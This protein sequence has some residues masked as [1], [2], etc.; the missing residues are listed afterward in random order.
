VGGLTFVGLGLHDVRDLSLKGFDAARSADAVFLEAYTSLLAGA[1][2]ETLEAHLGR[3]VEPLT[4]A[5]VEDGSAVLQAAQRGEAVLL[6]V[7]DSMMATTHVDL[8]VRA[9]KLGIA[10]RV[11][12]GASVLIAAAGLLGL[13]SYKFGRATTL[14][15]PHGDYLAESPYDVIAEN[16]ARGL[17]TLVLLDLDI[18]HGRFMTASQGL[19]LLLRIQERRAARG[20]PAPVGAD[21]L[22]CVVARAGSEQPLLRAGTIAAL[23]KEPFGP[24][25]HTLVVPGPLHELEE[26][27]LRVFAGLRRG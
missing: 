15:F 19:D 27:A 10:T 23:A 11:I 21:T 7:G 22:A 24:P 13:Q 17:H 18:E 16:L 9:A 26:E 8:R 2:V 5:Q 4:R 6:V 14:A 25:L 12:H 20:D 1:S 3:K